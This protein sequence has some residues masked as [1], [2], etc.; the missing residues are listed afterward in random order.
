MTVTSSRRTRHGCG[1]TAVLAA[2][3]TTLS[4]AA[5][6]QSPSALFNKSVTLSWTEYRVQR[7]DS[8]EMKRGNTDSVLQV[9]I[10]GEGRA[11]SRLNRRDGGRNS[12]NTDADPEGGS[13]KAGQGA[14]RLGVL[15]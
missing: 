4:G 13:T 15:R 8:G 5:A 10:S 6:E 3:V 12:N 7:C 1:L 2:L 9:Y 11:F 14:S